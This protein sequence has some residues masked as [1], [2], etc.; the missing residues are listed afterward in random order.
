VSE[1]PQI[2]IS[3]FSAVTQV[4]SPLISLWTVWLTFYFQIMLLQMIFSMFHQ[5]ITQMKLPPLPRG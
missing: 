4:L 5:V 3:D 1:I 2:T